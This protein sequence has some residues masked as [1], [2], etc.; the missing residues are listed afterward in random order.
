MKKP[1]PT[2]QPV[3]P[4]IRERWSPYWFDGRALDESDLRAILEA[5]RWA[6]SAYN[7]QPWSFIVAKRD[8][9]TEH[10]RMVSCLVEGNRT[11]AREAPVLILGLTRR[12]FRR[13]EE[14][15]ATCEHDLG[16]AAATLS[17]EATARG[18]FVHQMSGIEPERIR[19]AYAI[20]DDVTPLTALALGYCAAPSAVPERYRDRQHRA[21]ERDPLASFVFGARWGRPS[22][23][24]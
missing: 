17:L 6:P 9:A 11:W 7:E 8:D 13:T 15:N 16:L 2:E 5:A 21:R 19:E 24:V 14:A 10:E 3:H 20:P 1:A 23:L 22:P 18:I 12:R 4:L